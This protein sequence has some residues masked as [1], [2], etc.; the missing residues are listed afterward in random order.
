M[1]TT[2]ATATATVTATA[3]AT[4]TAAEAVAIT[5][6]AVQPNFNDVQPVLGLDANFNL[7]ELSNQQLDWR[8]GSLWYS[9]PKFVQKKIA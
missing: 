3:T 2:T 4:T 1:E 9:S 6:T 5:A 7:N 8:N